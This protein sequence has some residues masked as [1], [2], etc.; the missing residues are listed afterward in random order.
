MSNNNNQGEPALVLL[1]VLALL[2]GLF[3]IFWHIT[4]EFWLNWLFRWLRFGELWI[5]NLFAPH[6]TACLGWLRATQVEDPSPSPHVVALTN[7]CF[8]TEF[9]GT[10]P[11]QDRFAY[12]Q[13]APLPI[14]V[15]GAVAS[16][17]N[18]SYSGG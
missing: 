5:I 9:L 7:Q 17:C 10:Q 8:G 3:W 15:L 18:P 13:L 4:H 11:V 14:A 12:Y 16:T 1:M 6:Y 2:A